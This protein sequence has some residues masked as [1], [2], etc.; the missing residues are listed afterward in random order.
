MRSK[1][2][3]HT[4]SSPR[5]AKEQSPTIIRNCDGFSD[6][7]LWGQTN[8]AVITKYW[9]NVRRE[10]TTV[11][12]AIGLQF[13]L[14]HD[15]PT[16]LQPPSTLQCFTF[17]TKVNIASIIYMAGL[18]MASTTAASSLS[19]LQLLQMSHDHIHHMRHTQLFDHYGD[20]SRQIFLRR[21]SC[22]V[23]ICERLQKDEIAFN[24]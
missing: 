2:V 20:A 10:T 22:G 24:D 11:L 21:N 16:P 8:Q 14:Y 6:S 5:P 18:S 15:M 12:K 9:S 17:A 13:M 19:L 3:Q 1:V 7:L 23:V 4:G